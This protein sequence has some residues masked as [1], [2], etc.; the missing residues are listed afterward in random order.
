MIKDVVTS[1][2]TP[3]QDFIGERWIG[4]QNWGKF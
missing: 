1:V 4:T 2:K 3:I